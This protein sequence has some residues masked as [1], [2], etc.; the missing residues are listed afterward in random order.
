MFKCVLIIT[1]VGIYENLKTLE[2]CYF[3]IETESLT[4][5]FL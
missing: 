1:N 2:L 3:I 5:N 4:L